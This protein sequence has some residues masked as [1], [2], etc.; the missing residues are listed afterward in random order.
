MPYT[1]TIQPINP[2]ID[3]S[4]DTWGQITNDRQNE[5]YADING[6][7]GVANGAEAAAGAAMPKAGGA[8]TGEVRIPVTGPSGVDATGFRG[9]PRRQ[10]TGNATLVLADAGG[11]VRRAGTTV[12]DIT[13]P[14]LATVGFPLGT[15]IMLRNYSS[16]NWNVKR[17]SGAVELRSSR[18]V[19][20]KDFII[21]PLGAATIILEDTNMWLISGDAS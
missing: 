18:N 1:P 20:N 7:A 4:F 8:F 12:F 21:P 15:A 5:T 2:T 6:I 3:G 16:V 10:V 13:I 19:T 17:G 9:L 14:P 11:M